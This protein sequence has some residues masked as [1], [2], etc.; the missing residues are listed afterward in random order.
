MNDNKSEATVEVAEKTE[1]LN[2]SESNDGERLF[3]QEDVNRI[4]QKRL[5]G[6]KAEQK[7][8]DEIIEERVT[9][10]LADRTKEL[11][12]K[13]HRLDCKSYLIEN[14][15]SSDLLDIFDTSDVELFKKKVVAVNELYAT[16]GS[17]YPN[18]KDGGEV[19]NK[20]PGDNVRNAF[21]NTQPHK[22]KESNI[23]KMR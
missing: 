21:V 19:V 3:T 14:G 15:Y 12:A 7:A 11:D 20:P 4:V 22:P 18:V 16:K 8:N 10:A 17:H 2:S 13:E 9:E 23:Y 5:A 1:V 6:R